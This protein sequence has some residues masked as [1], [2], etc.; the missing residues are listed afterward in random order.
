MALRQ[1]ASELLIGSEHIFADRL[2]VEALAL[3]V[4][5]VLRADDEGQRV[6]WRAVFIAQ[7]LARFLLLHCAS[8]AMR[9]QA[10]RAHEDDPLRHRVRQLEMCAGMEPS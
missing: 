3:I 4:L 8:P 5:A 7:L 10:R 6:D 9:V 1:V 2:R